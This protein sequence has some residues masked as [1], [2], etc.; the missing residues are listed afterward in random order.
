MRKVTREVAF[1]QGWSSGR[2]AKV[3]ELFDSLA[4]EWSK[5]DADPARQAPIV[6]ALDRGQVEP[7]GQWVELGSGTGSG[8]RHLAER[9]DRLVTIDLSAQMLARAPDLAPKVRADASSLP[10]PDGSVDAVLAVNMLLFPDEIDRVLAR[11]GALV[12]VNTVGDQTPIHLSAA[13][14]VSALPGR[15]QAVT[16]RAGSGLWAAVRRLS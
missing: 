7:R 11:D 15:W 1:E 5:R 4:D 2:A 10:L 14:V 12:W 3:A 9:V 16:A 13:E 8:T 6:D